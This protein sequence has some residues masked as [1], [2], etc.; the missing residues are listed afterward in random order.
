MDELGHRYLLLGLRLARISPGFLDSYVGP[1]ELREIAAGESPPLA[2]EL[3]E[4][5]MALAELAASLP[6]GDA[7]TA[8]RRAWFGGQLRAMSTLARRAAG[9]EIS[10]LDLVE[11]LIAL[12]VTPVPDRDLLLVHQQLDDALPGEGSL[13]ERVA[14]LREALRIPPQHV[15]SA[16]RGSAERFRAATRR[17]FDLPDDEGIEWEEAHGRPWGAYAEYLGHRRTRIQVNVDLPIEVSG[18][19]FLASHEAYPGHHVDHIVKDRTLIAGADLGEA[20]LRTMGTPEAVIA[21]G[22]ADVAREVVMSDRELEAELRR[23]GRDAGIAGDWGAA[24]AVHGAFMALLSAQGNAGI[25]LH[26]GGRRAH[27]VR[28]YLADV[29]LVPDD[30]LDHVMRVLADPVAGMIFPYAEGARLIR[31]WL[32]LQGQT[33]GF[34]RLLSEQLSPAVL[35]ADLDADRDAGRTPVGGP[36]HP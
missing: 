34:W 17:D 8:R 15:V 6:G 20:T 14:R 3:H 23:I 27:E 11:E 13:R 33:A 10:Y 24:V 2:E 30:R 29:G 16:I 35:Q 36:V 1:G 7:P 26:H 21:E 12:R 32:E 25:M 28:A 4:E 22:L 18:A 5:A 31:P 19:A 9:E